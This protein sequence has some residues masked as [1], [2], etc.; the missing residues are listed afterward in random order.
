MVRFV[1]IPGGTVTVTDA[2]R[3]DSRTVNLQPF[4]IATT[5]VTASELATGKLSAEPTGLPAAGVGSDVGTGDIE[6]G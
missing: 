6:R 4:T 2:R 5:T 3:G 1:D